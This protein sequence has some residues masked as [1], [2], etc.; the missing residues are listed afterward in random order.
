MHKKGSCRQHIAKKKLVSTFCH[1]CN[2]QVEQDNNNNCLCCGWH[3]AR[4]RTYKIVM[5]RFDK[6]IDD[7]RELIDNYFPINSDSDFFCKVKIDLYTYMVH[8]KDFVEFR[9]LINTEGE[10]KYEKFFKSIKKRY[11]AHLT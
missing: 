10:D 2:H 3:I 5:K 7:H 4:S 6:I 11:E 9:N 8:I 1:K